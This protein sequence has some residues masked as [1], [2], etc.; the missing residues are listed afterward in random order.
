MPRLLR[1]SSICLSALLVFQR[2]PIS[3][4]QEIPAPPVP[5]MNI[6]VVQGE[7]AIHNLREPK[8]VD[9]VVR[10][11]DG[12]RNPVSGASVTFTLPS[13]GA[14]AT[15]PDKTKTAT[16]S[17][18][19]DGYAIARGLRPNKIPGSFHIQVEA[20][21]DGQNATASVTQFNM[22]VE[23][24]GGGSGKWIAILAVIGAAGAGGAVLA[25]RNGS[26]TAAAPTPIGLTPGSSSV[27]PPR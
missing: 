20:A 10:V 11:R 25:T 22:N 13:E 19:S 8:P 17:S 18:D 21:H 5:R 14:G 9:I 12:N 24:G 2:V 27:G 3:Y 6:V 26:S 23:S 7:A 15:F 1:F 16:A 4:A